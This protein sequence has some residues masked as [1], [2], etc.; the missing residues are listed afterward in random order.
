MQYL[1]LVHISNIRHLH[2]RGVACLADLRWNCDG[3][4]WTGCALCLHGDHGPAGRAGAE[5]HRHDDLLSCRLPYWS[6]H[7]DERCVDER[8]RLRR[9]APRDGRGRGASPLSRRLSCLELAKYLASSED[10]ILLG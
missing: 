5:V 10:V 6:Q 9:G 4:V 1:Y 2:L 3:D 7:A 8:A